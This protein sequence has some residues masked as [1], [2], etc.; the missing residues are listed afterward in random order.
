MNNQQIKKLVDDL[1]DDM[2]G[3]AGFDHD[4]DEET[5]DEWK[6]DWFEIIDKAANTPTPDVGDFRT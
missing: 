5:W 4:V 2:N 1:I 6:A 3:R